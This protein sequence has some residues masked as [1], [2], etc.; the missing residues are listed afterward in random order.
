MHKKDFKERFKKVYIKM[1]RFF[2]WENILKNT[3]MAKNGIY[4]KFAIN[5]I[6][7]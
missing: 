7:I 3:F 2:V 4:V 5:L 6:F 1:C